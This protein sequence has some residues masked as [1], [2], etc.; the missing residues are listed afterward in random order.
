MQANIIGKISDIATS[1]SIVYFN[2]AEEKLKLEKEV[3]VWLSDLES[4]ESTFGDSEQRVD[5][6]FNDEEPPELGLISDSEDVLRSA[7]ASFSS[8]SKNICFAAEDLTG[9]LQGVCVMNAE[10]NQL[11]YL[12]TAPANLP[13]AANSN[14]L[15]GVGTRLI[16]EAV[17]LCF[18][19]GKS[20]IDTFPTV[21]ARNYYLHL[22][23][24]PR[25]YNPK[26]HWLYLPVNL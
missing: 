11:K 24:I 9:T 25:D 3:S 6:L 22:G 15:R 16:R 5:L 18:T 21:S 14:P 4:L 10:L 8:E 23:F 7:K 13:I 12:A 20:V 1:L 17:R 26:S 19:N 2:N